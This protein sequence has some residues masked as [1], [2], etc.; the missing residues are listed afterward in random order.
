VLRL[1]RRSLFARLSASLGAVLLLSFAGGAWVSISTGSSILDQEIAD[2]LERS[3]H[4]ILADVQEYLGER[5]RE[6]KLWSGLEAM[7]DVLIQDS[8]LRIEN[9]LLNL[10]R[11]Y[12]TSYL[13]LAVLDVRQK[14]IA[15]TNVERIGSR[16]ELDSLHPVGGEQNLRVEGPVAAGNGLRAFLLS[17]PISSRLR[18]GIAGW[19]VAWVD[20]REVEGMVGAETVQGLPQDRSAFVL[21]ADAQGTVIAGSPKILVA[22][23]GAGALA[24][25]LGKDGLSSENL[26]AAGAFLVVRHTGE[27]ATYGIGR[28]WHLYAFREAGGAHAIVRVFVWSVVGAASL[29]LVLAAALSFF[30]ASGITRPI[31]RLT[32]GTERVAQGDLNHRVHQRGEDD[33]AGLARAFNAMTEE[34]LRMR[35]GLETQVAVRTH[36][37]E[38][39]TRELAEAVRTAEAATRA[40]S[41]FL[42]NMSHEIRTPMNGVLGMAEILIDTTLDREQIEYVQTIRASGQALLEIINDILDFSKIEAGKLSLELVDFSLRDS[43]A[44]TMRIVAPRGQSKG[45][46]MACHISPDLPEALVGD[47]GRIRQVLLNLIGNA[48]KFTDRGEIVLRVLREPAEG[49]GVVVHFAVSDTGIGIPAEKQALVFEAF[50]QADSSTTRKYGGTG[51]GLTIC[52]QIVDMMGGRIWVE[53]QHGQG[54]TFHFTACLGESRG[55]LPRPRPIGLS[56]LAGLRVLIVDDNATNRLILSEMVHH[57]GMEPLA[58]EGGAAALAIL[59]RARKDGRPYSLAL[60]DGHMPE[61][62]GFTLAAQIQKDVKRSYPPLVMLT[63]AGERGDAKRCRE[64]GVAGYLTKPV[65]ESELTEAIQLVMAGAQSEERPA[66]VTRHSMREKR[67]TLRVLLAEDNPVNRMVAVRFLEKRGHTV[68]AVEN[69]REA[70]DCLDK[71]TFDAVLMDVQMPVMDGFEATAAIR[72]REKETGAHV[73]IVALTA[74]AMKGDEARCRAAGMDAYVSKPIDPDRLFAAIES[75]IGRPADVPGAGN[76]TPAP[77]APKNGGAASIG[78]GPGPVP[79]S[80]LDPDVLLAQAGGN[81]EFLVE[82]IRVFRKDCTRQVGEI[83]DSLARGDAHALERAAHRLKGALGTLGARPASDAALALEMQGRD[84]SLGRAGEALAKLQSEIKRLDRELATL[85]GR[86]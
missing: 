74:H 15:S 31:R 58:V 39:K 33:L 40:K 51:L 86:N 70:L 13:E 78:G 4:T 5:G 72:F 12:P 66:L 60:I 28:D 64:L 11:E 3:A 41:E 69:G 26:G 82:V 45:L 24:R 56:A 25:S 85:S 67:R 53:S 50:T 71:E 44:E 37:L 27:D 55:E 47:P 22:L 52:R 18:P 34:L 35:Q 20:W 80:V 65:L 6:V 2:G 10:K 38:Q 81:R 23:P 19:L 46:E 54:S 30:I 32:H 14:V 21:L 16:V 8:A 83:R 57:L 73:P 76:G 1:L 43:L 61:M 17:H 36:E 49:G 68:V 84:G 63:S 75:L 42:A 59:D 79:P 48:I 29:G 9:L 7:D 62:D 77:V